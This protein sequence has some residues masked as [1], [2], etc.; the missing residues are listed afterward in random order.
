MMQEPSFRKNNLDC[1]RVLL[2]LTVVVFH[3][4]VLAQTAAYHP[5][6]IYARGAIAVKAFFV[7]S[8]MLIYRSYATS[9]SLT[10][11]CKKR[12]R[13]IYPAYAVVVGLV[14]FILLPLSTLPASLYFRSGFWKYL[15]ANL[16]FLN[17]AAP[18]LPGV[19]TVNPTPGVN[20]ALWTLKVEV[21][22]YL[23][24]PGISYLCGR[25]GTKPVLGAIAVFSLAWKYWFVY[26]GHLHGSPGMYADIEKQLPGQL[27]YFV[28]GILLYLYF[29]W[30]ARH[31]LAILCVSL[32]LL[33]VDSFF[34]RGML[35]VL[36]ISGMVFLFG[37]WRYLGN[38]SKYG[39][40]SYGI[41][42]VHYPIV[43]ALISLGL[44]KQSPAVFVLLVLTSVGV[45]AFLLW[46]VVEKRFLTRS[47][48]YR[49]ES[50]NLGRGAVAYVLG[51]PG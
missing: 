40:L 31:Y 23:I 41:Y 18:S 10:S 39:D 8:G 42:I 2:A 1:L 35:D 45:A 33:V 49:E 25:L 43:Q 5:L 37:F 12:A 7:I 51:E 46:H 34:C 21:L 20:G 30:L 14:P 29:E 28:A 9:S 48:H 26:L 44:A 50:T 36:W 4:G 22:F 19:F 15:C 6:A 27:I 17:H 38:F 11:Y 16:V 3:I 13:R 47:S 24:V 32:C